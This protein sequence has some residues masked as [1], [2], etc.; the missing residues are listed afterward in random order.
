MES[1]DTHG[2]RGG[3]EGGDPA[4]I[5]MGARSE[6]AGDIPYRPSTEARLH[7]H[8]LGRRQNAQARK[9]EPHASNARRIVCEGSK[10]QPL[11]LSIRK[12]KGDRDPE[13]VRSL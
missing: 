5:D 1:T 12:K 10:R 9:S 6:P 2:P 7:H 3:I 4:Q 8:V 13:A 11:S